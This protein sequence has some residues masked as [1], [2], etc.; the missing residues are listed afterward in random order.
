MRCVILRDDDTNALTPVECLEQLYRPFLDRGLPV[1]LA[2]IPKVHT[3]TI[4]TNGRLEQYLFARRSDTPAAVPLASNDRLVRYLHEN[5]GYHV[6]QHGCHHSLFEFDSYHRPEIAHRLDHGARELKAAG[7]KTPR[8]FVAPY[9]R[10]SSAS[11]QEAGKRFSVI[12]AGWFEL[13]RLP[14]SW[15]PGYAL[16]KMLK[17]THWKIGRTLLLTHPGCLLSYQRPY[18]TM[19]E[20]VK[21]CVEA[22]SLS[23]LVTH[24]WEYFRD[25]RPDTAMLQILHQTAEWLAASPDIQVISFDDLADRMTPDRLSSGIEEITPTR[26]AAA[27]E[28][29]TPKMLGF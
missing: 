28:F 15:W 7:F 13:K 24:W 5:P 8:T 27:E 20:T 6:L 10:F 19:L 11:L 25:G 12:S 3:D 9:D 17:R 1:N 2:T 14:V 26:Q 16:K 21:R 22:Q 18:A 23:V 29:K 4:S